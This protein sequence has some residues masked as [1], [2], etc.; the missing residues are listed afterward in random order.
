MRADAEKNGVQWAEPK[1]KRITGIGKVLRYS[2]LDELPQLVNI[3]KGELSFT[4]PRPE[5]PEFVGLLRKKIPYYD[6]RHLVKPGITGWAQIEYRY[7]SSVEDSAE[8]LKYDIYYIKNRSIF[9]DFAIVLKTFKS[10][11]INK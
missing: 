7:T 1:D 11:F 9:L 3:I 4:G 10:F 5:R 6:I 8:K 2:H